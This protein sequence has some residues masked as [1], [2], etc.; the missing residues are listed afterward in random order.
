M[1]SFFQIFKKLEIV[2]LTRVFTENVVI[3]NDI[4]QQ[5]IEESMKFDTAKDHSFV[6]TFNLHR[7]NPLFMR[8]VSNPKLIAPLC[9][10]LNG[11]P[12]IIQTQ[13]YFTPPNR[14]GLVVH[15]DNYYVEAENENFVSI[16][17]PL[18]DTNKENGGLYTF[19]GLH[20]RGS[21]RWKQYL[22]HRSE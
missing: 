6:P 17:I 3:D 22:K 18:V 9:S 20:K 21:S 10:I 1:A 14:N 16:W 5:L 15:Q 13:F 19:P 12:H 4:C 11:E 7:D 8:L 2:I